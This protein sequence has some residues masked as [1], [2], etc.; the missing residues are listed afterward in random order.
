MAARGEPQAVLA[1]G[2]SIDFFA[3][4]ED[5]QSVGFIVSAHYTIQQARHRRVFASVLLIA[6]SISVRLTL[7]PCARR[8]FTPCGSCCT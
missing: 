6:T 1:A 8:L 7:C 2:V 5:S 4:V 3:N